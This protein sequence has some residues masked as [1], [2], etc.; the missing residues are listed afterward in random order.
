LR[1][2]ATFSLFTTGFLDLRLIAS[3]LPPDKI[4]SA[5]LLENPRGR[6]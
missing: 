4:C 5:S 1:R 3:P 6:S 2:L